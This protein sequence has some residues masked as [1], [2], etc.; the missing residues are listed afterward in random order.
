MP[1]QKAQVAFGAISG[2]EQLYIVEYSLGNGAYR[3]K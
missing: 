2:K 1:T 3:L